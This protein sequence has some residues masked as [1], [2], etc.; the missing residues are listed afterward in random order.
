MF[1]GGQGYY[2]D[3]DIDL[4]WVRRRLYDPVGVGGPER[5]RAGT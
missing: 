5:V 1:V 2:Q 4:Y 3:A